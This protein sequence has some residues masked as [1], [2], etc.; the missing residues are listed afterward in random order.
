MT[1]KD[2][3]AFQKYRMSE[4]TRVLTSK[5]YRAAEKVYYTLTIDDNNYWKQRFADIEMHSLLKQ[6]PAET[7]EECLNWLVSKKDK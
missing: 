5:E 1:T 7:I 3:A 4:L 2:W 6:V